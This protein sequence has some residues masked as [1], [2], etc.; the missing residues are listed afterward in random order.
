VSTQAQI[1]QELAAI[2]GTEG[3]ASGSDF[4][5]R[6]PHV[7]FPD[8]PKPNIVYP[9]TPETLANLV[10]YAQRQ[11][12]SVIPTGN[13]SKLHWGGLAKT[14]DLLVS[15]AR[16]N[17]VIDHAVGDLTVTVEAGIRFAELQAVL[18]KAGQFLAIDPA[19][20]D[21]ATL[22]GIVA[23]GDAGSLRHRYGGVRDMLLGISFVR[24]DGQIAKAGGRVVKNVAGYDLMKLFTGSY[25]TLGILTQLT[26]R[27]YPLPADSQTV[28]LQGEPALIAEAAQTIRSSALTPTALDLLSPALSDRLGLGSAMALLVSFQSISA[29]VQEQAKRVKEVTQVLGLNHSLYA[30]AEEAAL[31]QALREVMEAPLESEA[32]VCK[33]GLRSAAAANTLN[34]LAQFRQQPI[35][36]VVHT[37][38]GVGKLYLPTGA[39]REHLQQLRQICQSQNGFLSVLQAPTSIK[40][41]IDVWGYPGNALQLMQTLKQHFDPQNLLSPHRFVSG[42]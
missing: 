16:L 23:T 32:V 40:Q 7:L 24:S 42:I 6:L 19:Y 33:I 38:S 35:L 14:A 13:G 20:P 22:G 21:C 11:G 36:S 1:Q 28:V 4:A 29:S 3:I 5:D 12:W 10:H 2:V 17:Q 15:T 37:G 39:T 18:A 27:V 41:S 26:F 30:N 9:N 34:E 8:T 31:W 25:G